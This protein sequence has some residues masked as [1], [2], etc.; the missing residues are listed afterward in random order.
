[1]VT[2]MWNMEDYSPRYQKLADNET[3]ISIITVLATSPPLPFLFSISPFLFK[4]M[5]KESFKKVI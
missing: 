2:T 3:V 5:Y 1:M 4:H